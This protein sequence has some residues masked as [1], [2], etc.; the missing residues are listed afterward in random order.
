SGY[1]AAHHRQRPL[2]L[3]RSPRPTAPGEAMRPFVLALSILAGLLDSAS[4]ADLKLLTAGAYKPVAL[5][6]I[7][8][9]EQKTGHKVTV[10]NDTAGGLAKRVAAGEYFDIVIM[11]P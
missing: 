10:E 2:A 3:L 1:L 4:A 8:D 11:P 9:F 7:P 5:E 6:I